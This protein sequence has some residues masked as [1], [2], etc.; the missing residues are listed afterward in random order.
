MAS[1]KL[2]D[3]SAPSNSCSDIATGNFAVEPMSERMLRAAMLKLTY[4]PTNVRNWKRVLPVKS[5]Q[6]CRMSF[7]EQSCLKLR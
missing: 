7:S 5:R 1:Q 6:R 3:L 4:W 2:T